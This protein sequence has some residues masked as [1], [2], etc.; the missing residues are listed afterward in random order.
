MVLIVSLVFYM[1]MIHLIHLIK[2]LIFNIATDQPAIPAHRAILASR[3][4]VMAAMCGENFA[5]SSNKEVCINYDM[6][7]FQDNKC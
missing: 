5:E 4:E 7:I 3:S 2:R 1:H 6:V